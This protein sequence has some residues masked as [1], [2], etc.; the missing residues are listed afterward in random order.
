M[1]KIIN[2]HCHIYPEAIAERAVQ[3]IGSFY[4]IRLDLNG[5]TEDLIKDGE[6]FGVVHYLVHSVATKPTQVHTINEF[7]DSEVK[8]HDGLFTGFGTLH[9]DSETLEQDLEHLIKLGL[10]GVKIHP[11]C[12]GY[13]L[14]EDKALRLG[15]L[16]SDAGLPLLT[17]CGDYRFQRSN[18]AQ[19][20]VFLDS[21]PDLQVIGAHLGGWSMWD[22]VSEL[23]AGKYNI[24]VDCCSCFRFMDADKAVKLIRQ[25][26]ADKVL[27]GT[28]YPAWDHE[29]E[30]KLWDKLEL[31]SEERSKILYENAAKL[32]HVEG[33]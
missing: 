8:S 14:D 18:P 23:I 13:A 26:G 28:D 33:D 9:P 17:H 6:R 27:W 11:D 32:L 7:I 20:K 30:L 2:A 25:F 10:K 24:Y 4:G 12:Q 29:S 19:F 22:E 3:G 1:Q 5:T 21:L 15:K 16:V 31:T